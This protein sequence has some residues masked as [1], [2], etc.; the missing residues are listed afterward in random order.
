MSV[1]QF[2][3]NGGQVLVRQGLTNCSSHPANEQF[4][5]FGFVANLTRV[6]CSRRST[7]WRHASLR[8]P[9]NGVDATF[10][11]SDIVDQRI[12]ICF[13]SSLS[14]V[15]SAASRMRSTWNQRM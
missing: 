12:R 11:R 7:E 13:Q 1:E 3:K 9:L 4:E 15:T 6:P 5:K 14:R 2:T 8:K 10:V